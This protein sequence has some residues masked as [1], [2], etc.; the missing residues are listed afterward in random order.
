LLETRIDDWDP[1]SGPC[2][3][4]EDV[5]CGSSPRSLSPVTDIWRPVSPVE[6]LRLS[7]SRRCVR[8]HERL[9]ISFGSRS[10]AGL[11]RFRLRLSGEASQP[12]LCAPAGALPPDLARTLLRCG[13]IRPISARSASPLSVGDRWPC[14]TGLASYPSSCVF[15][16]CGRHPFRC[17]PPGSDLIAFPWSSP[18]FSSRRLPF[19]SL[20]PR[21][22]VSLFTLRLRHRTVAAAFV[23]VQHRWM[24]DHHTG[25]Q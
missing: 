10:E 18:G 24:A 20:N 14:A 2:G 6:R 25:S 15:I 23:L 13:C 3:P 12:G 9:Q 7:V 19:G 5:G 1:P 11:R 17:L 4:R 16:P 8:L 21:R 22:P